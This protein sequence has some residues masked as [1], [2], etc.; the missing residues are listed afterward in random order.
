MYFR[1]L[2]FVLILGVNCLALTTK[3]Q[4]QRL[5]TAMQK[6]VATQ[7]VN[8]CSNIIL[9]KTKVNIY[10]SNLIGRALPFG[11]FNS[12][13]LAFEYLYGID[14]AIAGLPARPWT[15]NS[16][17]MQDLMLDPNKL[18]ASARITLHLTQNERLLF[19]VYV[20]FDKNYKICGF[21]FQ[22]R[23]AGLTF[24]VPAAA[25]AQLISQLC[26][27]IQAACTGNNTQYTS[28]ADCVNFM[29]NEIPFGTYDAA[30]QSNVICRQVHLYLALLVPEIHCPHCGKTGGTMCTD[31]TPQSY[32]SVDY[33]AC[34]ADRV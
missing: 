18:L 9:G 13:L 24:A 6:L 3:Q 29:T 21:D 5:K 2:L 11:S 20:A 26:T 1:S 15:V 12:A 23:N 10:S 34:A 22:I 30:D 17:T 25:D 32:F 4:N 16:A 28:Q 33:L 19:F 8:V 27:G 7:H 14:C 31:K